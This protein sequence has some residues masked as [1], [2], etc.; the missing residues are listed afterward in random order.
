MNPINN[1]TPGKQSLQVPSVGPHG[2]NPLLASLFLSTT[3]CL[4]VMAGGPSLFP[5]DAIQV[6]LSEPLNTGKNHT[7]D[8]FHAVIDHAVEVNG[9]VAI[10][11]GA[12]IEGTL[13]NVVSSGRLRRRAEVTLELDTI[14]IAGRRQI[15]E[16]RPE[17]RLGS[18]H[19]GHDGKYIGGA[20]LFGTV[21]GAL[22]GGGKGAGIGAVTGAAAG[23][24]A[25]A[26]TGKEEL[27]VPSETVIIFRL[28]TKFALE[29]P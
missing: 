5:G 3:V 12:V 15:I 20:A 27:F 18:S 6:R 13:T 7:G 28:K 14:E 1:N 9:L 4:T 29:L 21:V 23:S 24:G 19:S 11:R 25:A 2:P 26:V 8:R 16:V 22:A 10:P 17:T